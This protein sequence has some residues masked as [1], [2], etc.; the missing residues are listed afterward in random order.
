MMMLETSKHVPK[1]KSVVAFFK[2][3]ATLVLSRPFGKGIPHYLFQVL[4]S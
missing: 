1:L 4:N 2:I 3:L